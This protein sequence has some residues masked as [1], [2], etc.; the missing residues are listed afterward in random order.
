MTVT[1]IA[2]EIVMWVVRKLVVPLKRIVLAGPRLSVTCKTRPDYVRVFSLAA[3][4]DLVGVDGFSVAD[5][6]WRHGG[7]EAKMVSD[8]GCDGLGKRGKWVVCRQ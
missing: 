2:L 3:E 7:M 8:M 1:T 4:L 6:L 5:E